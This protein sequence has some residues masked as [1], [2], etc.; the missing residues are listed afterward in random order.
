[1]ITIEYSIGFILV[2]LLLLGGAILSGYQYHQAK[3]QGIGRVPSSSPP[4]PPPPPA[5]ESE[6]LA[7]S[8]TTAPLPT[9]DSQPEPNQPTVRVS[10]VLDAPAP[11]PP[12]SRPPSTKSKVLPCNYYYANSRRQ[13]TGPVTF[14]D[15]LSLEAAGRLTLE[16][17]VIVE[18]AAEW[19]NWRTIKFQQK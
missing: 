4:P 13:P 10:T 2:S 5:E 6:A 15:L 19:S 12:A 1:L 8:P 16:S 18:G 14:E 7:P 3:G 17:K 9:Q 11:P